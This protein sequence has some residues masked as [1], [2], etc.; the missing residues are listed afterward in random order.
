MA[1]KKITKNTKIGEIL[2]TN[3]ELAE[4]L[5]GSGMGC[6][7]CPAAQVETLEEGCKAHGM[8]DKDIDKL[9]IKVNK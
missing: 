4:V 9:L 6:C 5:M 2:E 8:T 3:P 7:G 1:K